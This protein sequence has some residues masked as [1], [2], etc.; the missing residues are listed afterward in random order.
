MLDHT[1]NKMRKLSGKQKLR[2]EVS[3]RMELIEKKRKT[4]AYPVSKR[5]NLERGSS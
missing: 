4:P 1:I 5:M 2:K 3:P